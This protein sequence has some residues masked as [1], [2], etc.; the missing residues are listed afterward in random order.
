MEKVI[1]KVMEISMKNLMMVSS[2]IYL[3]PCLCYGQLITIINYLA[4]FYI[5]SQGSRLMV[6]N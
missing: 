4:I 1:E 6:V 5:H 3:C 2:L